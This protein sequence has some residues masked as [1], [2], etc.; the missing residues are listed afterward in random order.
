MRVR[1][2]A[3]I[4]ALALCGCAPGWTVPIDAQD[5]GVLLAAWT[6]G[7]DLVA[8]GGDLDGARGLIVRATAD[9]W[10][11]EADATDRP[12]WWVHGSGARWFGVGEAGLIVREEGGVRSDE[13]VPTDATLFGVHDTGSE[14]WAVGGTQRAD[15]PGGEVWRR[16]S[17]GA[18]T[19]VADTFP[20]PLFKVHEDWIVGVG[21]SWQIVGDQ[22]EE[23]TA[24]E[25]PR[26]LTV[27]KRGDDDV[28]A[29]GGLSEAEV[30]HWTGSWARVEM[31]PFCTNQALN[32]VWTGPGEDVWVA[33][34]FGAMM[35][36]DGATWDCPDAPLTQDHFHA[37][38]PWGDE[39]WFFGGD[40]FRLGGNHFT[41]GRYG[42]GP[43]T[44]PVT[45]C[46]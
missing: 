39:R 16:D 34:Q 26:L 24:D 18:W 27:R 6:A 35:R 8:V 21:S 32:G 13:S 25:E 15:V 3:T 10:C 14:V 31:D 23:R 29:V 41:I 42:Q 11:A 43:K 37:T 4:A 28:W 17:D 40:L 19:L 45:A 20:G 9:G 46:E 22:L 38:W 30:W 1:R 2:A 44:V 7:D 5:G 33:G 36:W 12:I